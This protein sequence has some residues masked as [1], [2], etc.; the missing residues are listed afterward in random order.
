M[1]GLVGD[2]SGEGL[3]DLDKSQIVVTV[4]NRSCATNDLVLSVQQHTHSAFG[5]V[6]VVVVVHNK[7]AGSSLSISGDCELPKLVTGIP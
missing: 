7:T 2:R 6:F 4:S 1:V 5:L 3:P